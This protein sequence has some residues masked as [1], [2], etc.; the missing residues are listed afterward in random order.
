MKYF[1]SGQMPKNVSVKFILKRLEWYGMLLHQEI[2][3]P[4]IIPLDR[5]LNQKVDL[6]QA[7]Q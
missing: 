1:L 4:Q 3:Q 2:L 7:H 6:E 5:S